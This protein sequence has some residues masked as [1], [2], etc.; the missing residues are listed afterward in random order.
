MLLDKADVILEANEKDLEYAK[1]TNLDPHM[2]AR[3]KL[4]KAKLETLSKG[5]NDIS[6]Q[7]DPIGSPVFPVASQTVGGKDLRRGIGT[8]V[9]AWDQF[10]VTREL[11]FPV[12]R[13]SRCTGGAPAPTTRKGPAVCA[14]ERGGANY[15]ELSEGGAD[16]LGRGCHRD[17]VSVPVGTSGCSQWFKFWRENCLHCLCPGGE[18]FGGQ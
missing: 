17:E 9:P 18:T 3:L 10:C 1:Q 7:P 8:D 16:E 12:Q 11:L 6:N 15:G 13:P 2:L 4:S 14:D 5:I